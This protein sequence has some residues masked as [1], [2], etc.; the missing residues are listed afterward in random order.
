MREDH[1]GHSLL[2]FSAVRD[3]KIGPNCQMGKAPDENLLDSL[4][5]CP[6]PPCGTEKLSRLVPPC[7]AER[8]GSVLLLRAWALPGVVGRLAGVPWASLPLPS[9]MAVRTGLCPSSLGRAS[10]PLAYK[11]LEAH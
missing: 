8:R 2:Q 5:S 9:S 1:G 7:G 3:L 10:H 4:S 6:M 11:T